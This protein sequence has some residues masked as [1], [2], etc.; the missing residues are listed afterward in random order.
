MAELIGTPEIAHV[1]FIDIVGYST[2][3]MEEQHRLVGELQVGVRNSRE[4]QRCEL[5][6]EIVTLDRGD[7]MVLVFSRNPL[8]TLVVAEE[9]TAALA[10]PGAPQVRLGAHTGPVTRTT[11]ISGNP[12]FSGSGLNVGQ[13]VMDAGGPGQ[14][15][16]S[17][18]VA[19]IVSDFEAY[20][21]RLQDLGEITAKHGRIVQVFQLLPLGG[22]TPAQVANTVEAPESKFSVSILYKRNASLDEK[23]V[24]D[25]ETQL[26]K[27]GCKVFVDRHLAIGVEWAQ[28]IVNQIQ[29]SDAVII[30]LSERSSSSEML[31]FEVSEANRA[32]Q[33]TGKPRLFPVRVDF[34]GVLGGSL[35]PMLDKLQYGVWRSPDDT[36]G[37]IGSIREAL[38]RPHEIR[39][40]KL[41]QVGG[42]VPLDSQYYI[43]RA[44]D[45]DFLAA[46]ERKE[47]IVLVK[48]ARQ[49]GKTSLLA[50][51]LNLARESST[52]VVLTDFQSLYSQDLE[53]AD[54]LFLTLAETFVDQLDLDA[55]PS[56]DW[57][58]PVG[59][60]I[61][62]ERFL[63]R[64]VLKDEKRHIVWGLDEVDR[65]FTVPYGSEVFGL[66]RSWHNRRSLEPAGPWSRLT[67][68]IAYATEAHLFIKD[69][70]QSPFNVG[71]RLSL[72]DFSKEQVSE[73]NRRYGQPL[74]SSTELDAFFK[75]LN[76]QPYLVRRALDEM[77]RGRLTLQELSDNGSR[78]EGVFGDH[79]RRLLVSVSHD[80][81][82]LG[83]LR[84]LLFAKTPLNIEQFSRL[85][86]AGVLA[87]ESSD[88][89]SPRCSLYNTYLRRHL[90]PL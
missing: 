5:S 26:K 54:Q 38:T 9:L 75:L 68:A 58:V 80:G 34:L 19:E 82:L 24:V 20:S 45:R 79:L 43:E 52:S 86:S 3:S 56:A 50:R 74:R 18:A 7:G 35:G 59:A 15:M 84:G 10:Y 66:F 31:E 72:H 11:D 1:L 77:A 62:F 44:T 51:G 39:G 70:N 14:I 76:G 65:L 48:G 71:T 83:A 87:G 60:G 49:M 33:S 90:E 13:R 73:L 40:A 63:R 27:G 8:S 29:A 25:F 37:I 30:L 23:A 21:E 57:N 81:E 61:K 16:L 41:E 28:E 42:A 46:I 2:K 36:D 32:Y 67:L 12:N 69:L 53:S 89:A 47:S 55:S 4:F 85:R 88:D 17:S 22:S 6:S 64:S 78:D